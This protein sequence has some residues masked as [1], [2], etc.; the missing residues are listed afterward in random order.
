MNS[1]LSANNLL[2][3]LTPEQVTQLIQEAIMPLVARLEIPV[4]NLKKPKIDLK[5]SGNDLLSSK[6]AAA[7]LGVSLSALKIWK[8]KRLI[9]YS[10]ASYKGRIFFRM[11]DLEAFVEKNKKR[12]YH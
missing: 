2:V 11:S 5:A 4:L 10:Q 12:K 7:F 1:N 8:K 9:P 6:E 3:I